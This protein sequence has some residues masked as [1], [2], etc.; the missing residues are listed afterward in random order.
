[1]ADFDK[2]SDRKGTIINFIEEQVLRF[3]IHEHVD[4]RK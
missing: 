2:L 1:M 3:N 4:R